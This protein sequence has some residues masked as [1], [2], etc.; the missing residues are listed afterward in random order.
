MAD[1]LDVNLWLAFSVEG[2][3]HHK[4]A[5]EA[6]D[7]L[8]RPTFCRVTHLGWMRLLCNPQVM[9]KEVLEPQAAWEEYEKVLAGGVVHFLEEP[10]RLEP[11]LKALT[12]GATARRD[13]WTGAYLAAFAQSAGM[14]MV[15]FDAGFSRFKDL[16]LWVLNPSTVN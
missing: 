9:G 4:A 7:G 2:H 13:F 12:V 8:N 10:P 14:R 3:P 11:Y 1:L 6:W 16:D 5:M 15:T